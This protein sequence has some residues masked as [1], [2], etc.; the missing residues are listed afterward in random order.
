MNTYKTPEDAL[1]LLLAQTLND[2]DALP[3]YRKYASQYKEAFLRRILEKVMSIEDK[4]IKK[5][6]GALFT[7]LVSHHEANTHLRD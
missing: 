6:R 4:K 3:F 5:S 7:Y 1:A 2:Y